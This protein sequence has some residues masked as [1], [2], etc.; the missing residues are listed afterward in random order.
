VR[1]R[2]ARSG[3]LDNSWSELDGTALTVASDDAALCR[4]ARERGVTTVVVLESIADPARNR[5]L[6]CPGD[7][8]RSTKPIDV[9]GGIG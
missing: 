7:D 9:P 6:A 1:G 5:V 2:A 3:S 8:R 4:H